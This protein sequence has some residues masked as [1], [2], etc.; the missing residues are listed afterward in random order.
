MNSGLN[1]S[2]PG[3]LRQ[4]LYN[5]M[6]LDSEDLEVLFVEHYYPSTFGF[7]EEEIGYEESFYL[8]GRPVSRDELPGEVTDTVIAELKSAAVIPAESTLRRLNPADF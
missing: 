4:I 6:E 5:W 3:S 8:E 2:H 1:R 7:P